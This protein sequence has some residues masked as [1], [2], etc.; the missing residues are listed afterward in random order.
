MKILHV[1]FS[2]SNGGAAIAMMRLH[3]ALIDQNIDSKVLVMEKN[4]NDKNVFGPQKSFDVVL[5]DI[6]QIITK[7]KRYF[8]FNSGG[9]SHS[10]NIFNSNILKRIEEINP[11]IVNLHWVNNELLSIKQI[12]K[13]KKPTVWTLVDMWPMC[14]GEHYTESSRYKNGYLKTNKDIDN[15][16]IDLNKILWGRKIKNWNNKF[17]SIICISDWLKNKASESVIFKN[18]NI[19]KI[20]CN[21]NTR[22]WTPIDKNVARDILKLDKKEKIFLFLSTNG[23][24]NKIKGFKFIDEAL[25]KISKNYDKF[26]L[27]I[28]GNER[29]NI[30]QKNYKHTLI[31]KSFGGNMNELRLLYSASDLLLS[32]SIMEAFGQVAIEA[33]SCGTPT[34]AFKNTGF[35]DIIKNKHNGYIANYQDQ[36]DFTLGVEWFLNLNDAD[37]SNISKNCL[38]IV[39]K[40][41]DDRLISQEYINLYKSI[42]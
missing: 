8:F 39:K 28:A 19:K 1:G 24:T 35:E 41:F 5:N 2:D 13:I 3:S 12:G 21:I 38:E 42:L 18:T 23:A 30:G 32:P 6:K 29:R 15:K 17:K 22:D 40:K 33:A 9:Y 36:N 26:R 7:S 16:L 11:D 10:L 37:I 4:T 20:N 34:I 27:I 14:G 31:N 25:S